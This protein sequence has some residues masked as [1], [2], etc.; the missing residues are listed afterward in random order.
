M[1]MLA[2]V[3]HNLVRGQAAGQGPHNALPREDPHKQ[4]GQNALTPREQAQDGGLQLRGGVGVHLQT[5]TALWQVPASH[6]YTFLEAQ[7]V[8]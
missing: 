1:R 6:L 4:I 5:Y 3:A 8:V 2:Q 7:E